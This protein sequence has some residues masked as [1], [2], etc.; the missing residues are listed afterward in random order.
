MFYYDPFKLKLAALACCDVSFVLS[1][2]LAEKYI[3]SQLLL[4]T[5]SYGYFV[6]DEISKYC[7]LINYYCE[8]IDIK[9]S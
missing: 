4:P 2:Q 6:F 3:N 7:V 8:F 9:L 5:F 1:N